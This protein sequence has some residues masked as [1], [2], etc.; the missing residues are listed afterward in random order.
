MKH[1]IEKMSEA[2]AL[3]KYPMAGLLEGWY[4]RVT[5]TSNDAWFAEGTDLWGRQ[6]SCRVEGGDVTPCIAMAKEVAGRK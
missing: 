3:S 5:E 2:E 4:F 1:Q 6:V